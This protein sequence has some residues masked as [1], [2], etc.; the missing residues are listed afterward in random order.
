MQSNDPF[1]PPNTASNQG[2]PY[3][4][5]HAYP[6]G[7]YQPVQSFDLNRML[8]APFKSPNWLTNLLWMFVCELLSIVVIGTLIKFGYMAEVAEARSG[9]R[10]ENWPDFTWERFTEYVMRGLWP[11]TLESHLDDSDDHCDWDTVGSHGFFGSVA[12]G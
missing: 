10:S 12:D 3:G 4:G 1:A 11:F 9:G 5:F 2:M 7:Y 6:D 8:V